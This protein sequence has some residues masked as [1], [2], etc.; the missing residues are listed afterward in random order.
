MYVR[1]LL[2]CGAKLI[3]IYYCV[4]V[5]RRGD[6]KLRGYDGCAERTAVWTTNYT[7]GVLVGG[8]RKPGD[9]KTIVVHKVGR[10]EEEHV[11]S[12]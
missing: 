4:R 1:F 11:H 8:G 5:S 12:I 3:C 2:S 9:S 7:G 6:R 10:V